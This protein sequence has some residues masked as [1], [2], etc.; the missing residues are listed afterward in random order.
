MLMRF[1]LLLAVLGLLVAASAQAQDATD[2]DSIGVWDTGLAGKLTATQTGFQ[3]WNQGGV[4][5]FAFGIGVDGSAAH[6]SGRWTQEHGL[7]L[8]FGMIRQDIEG[9]DDLRKSEDLILFKS[10][11]VYEGEGFFAQ[12][13]PTIAQE[14]RS[15]FASGFNYNKN[16]FPDSTG[17]PVKVSEFLAPGTFQQAVGLT[18]EPAAWVST[19]LGVEAKE[20]VVLVDEFRQLYGVDPD[21]AVLLEVGLGLVTEVNKQLA[22][23]ITYQSSLGVFAAFNKPESP[24][25]LWENFIV[26]KVNDWMSVNFEFVTLYDRDQSNAVQLR[27]VLAVGISFVL[28]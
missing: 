2:T 25:V 12:F 14:A 7:R 20:T 27:E 3:N 8:S 13:Q 1:S 11:L 18:Y 19:R 6:T 15:Q 23:N 5:S 9:A 28:I 26:M 4:N 17:T 16:P 10:S 21:Q 24:D 22:E